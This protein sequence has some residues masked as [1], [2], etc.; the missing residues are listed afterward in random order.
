MPTFT[1]QYRPS[2][3]RSDLVDDKGQFRSGQWHVFGIDHKCAMARAAYMGDCNG[4]YV[5]FE[6]FPR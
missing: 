6:Y 2:I 3:G 1:L 4:Y 5:A